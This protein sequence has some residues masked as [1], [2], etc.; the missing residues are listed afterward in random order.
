MTQLN[1]TQETRNDS[2]TKRDRTAIAA[3]ST[4]VTLLGLLVTSCLGAEVRPPV[5]TRYAASL[6]ESIWSVEAVDVN[7]DRRLDLIAM[8]ETKVFALTS[9][10]APDAK[11]EVLVDT[12][13]PKMLYCVALDADQDGDMDIAV[14]RYREPWIEIRQAR[15]AGK[16][17]PRPQGS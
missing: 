16:D 3:P 15:A 6:P 12:K 9:P 14:G 8:G 17:T 7:Q 5:W 2:A 4:I 13:E 10:T 1:T 11:A